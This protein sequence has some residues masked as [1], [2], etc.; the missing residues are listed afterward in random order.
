MKLKLLFFFALIFGLN[1]F[2]Q[3]LMHNVDGCRK[4]IFISENNGTYTSIVA[5]PDTSTGN[6]VDYTNTNVS[7]ISPNSVNS[8]NSQ[9]IFKLPVVIEKG[10]DFD[11][12]LKVYSANSGSNNT[13]SGRLLI[14]LFNSVQGNGSAGD[15]WQIASVDK[16][17]GWQEISVTS[18]IPT[19][20][21]PINFDS[22]QIIGLNNAATG[23][24]ED[25]YFDDFTIDIDP[26]LSDTTADLDAGNIWYYNNAI[27][28]TTYTDFRVGVNESIATPTTDGNSS[29]NVMKVT[30]GGNIS[31]Q[32]RIHHG[33]IDQTAGGVI[34]F[35]VY[36]ECTGTET[37]PNITFRLRKQND[38]LTQYY[39]DIIYLHEG[40]WNE[41]EITLGDLTND[42]SVAAGN[43]YDGSLLLFNA[44]TSGNTP[45]FVFYIDSFQGPQ[46]STSWT[47]ATDSDWDTQD[48]WSAE[49]PGSKVNAIVP[50][51][52]ASLIS[53][54]TGATVNDLTV[55]A[56]SSLT[57]DSGGS[58]TVDGE[59]TLESSSTSYSSL[60]LD[61]TVSG[62]INYERH[63]NINGSGTTGSN[64][65]ISAP[66]TGQQFDDFATANS[67]ILSNGAGTLFLFGPFDKTTGDYLTYADTETATLDAGVGYRAASDDNGTFTFT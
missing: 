18:N 21:S 17:G 52:T 65:L 34:K 16:T 4:M 53:A 42:G 39:A 15:R 63:V 31:H 29:V 47:G 38:A 2:S 40:L 54:S 36:P 25:F 28:G 49:I 44:E 60:I 24:S 7:L 66:L 1:A 51:L 50:A 19:A 22:V 30:R 8:N 62:T 41:V 3:H 26:V 27:L 45:P 10:V 5:N 67:N 37:T 9:A 64:D 46:G 56:S 13:G 6:T 59:L 32:L 11:W 55:E 35:R 12:S 58:L 23:A 20:R 33:D 14:R 48:N 57:V 43:L 61:G